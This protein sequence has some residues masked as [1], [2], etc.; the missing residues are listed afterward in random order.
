MGGESVDGLASEMLICLVVGSVCV[1]VLVW[2]DHVYWL[3]RE[4]AA[5]RARGYIDVANLWRGVLRFPSCAVRTHGPTRDHSENQ[6]W[7]I[8]PIISSCSGREH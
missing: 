8:K 1:L 2:W 3:D 5:S 6:H 4:C 7:G